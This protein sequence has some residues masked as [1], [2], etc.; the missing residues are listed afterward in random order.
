MKTITGTNHFSSFS[1]AV[2]YYKNYG[3]SEAEVRQ[4][5]Q[6]KEIFVGR[7][8]AKPW[9]KILINKEEGRYF[10]SGE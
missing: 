8:V 2:S 10:I 3:I 4:K 1:H 5:I 6:N 9:Q 7:P